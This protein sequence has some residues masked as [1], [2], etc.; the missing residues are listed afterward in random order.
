MTVGG[1]GGGGGGRS[2]EVLINSVASCQVISGFQALLKR[3]VF[4]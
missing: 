2:L 4:D 3:D 1:W